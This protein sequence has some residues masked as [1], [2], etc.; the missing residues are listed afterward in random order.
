MQRFGRNWRRGVVLVAALAV[1]VFVS[2]TAVGFPGGILFA[3][4][5]GV[6][7]SVA[8][9]G[10]TRRHNCVPGFLRRRRT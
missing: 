3:I 7:T 6:A 1:I 9:F 5:L 4:S 2:V 8:V 10:D